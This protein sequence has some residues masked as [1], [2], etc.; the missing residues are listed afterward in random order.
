[1]P[2]DE[3]DQAPRARPV[4]PRVSRAADNARTAG[5]LAVRLAFD[6]LVIDAVVESWLAGSPIRVGLAAGA[7]VY[8]MLTAYVVSKGG[9]V[10]GRGWLMDP[11][12][13]AIVFLGFLVACS[14]T[15][16]W[17][18]HGIHALRHPAPYVLPATFIALV[19]AAAWRMVAP[20]GTRSWSIRVLMLLVS[21][22]ACAAFARSIA[23]HAAFVD[24]LTG[25]GFWPGLPW[26]LQGTWIGAFLILPVAFLRELGASIA[27]LET[28]PYLRWMLVFGVGCWIAFNVASL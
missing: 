1:V 3:T 21:G 18:V 14:W 9:R 20:G 25:H 2:T 24:M 12:T 16:E 6:L 15:R 7:A 22:Y 26:W 11:L 10:S 19:V 27:R 23:G 8:F 17:T 28:S 5:R 13:G 4:G